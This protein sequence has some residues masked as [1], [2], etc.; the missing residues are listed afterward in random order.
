M[1]VRSP[2]CFLELLISMYILRARRKR[3]GIRVR[4]S[5]CR[6]LFHPCRRRRAHGPLPKCGQAWAQRS[7]AAR[8]QFVWQARSLFAELRRFKR[9]IFL[10]ALMKEWFASNKNICFHIFNL[11]FSRPLQQYLMICYHSLA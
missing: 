3:A 10:E 1:E 4:N 2:P 5:F 6:G 8:P 11:W 9:H 7:G